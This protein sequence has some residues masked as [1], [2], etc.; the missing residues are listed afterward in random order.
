[1]YVCVCVC[2]CVCACVCV[3]V[4]FFNISCS[5]Q[6]SLQTLIQH[7]QDNWGTVLHFFKQ[8]YHQS[9]KGS[10]F[11][12]LFEVKCQC[13]ALDALPILFDVP[14]LFFLWLTFACDLCDDLYYTIVLGTT[15]QRQPSDLKMKMSQ[16][17]FFK[18]DL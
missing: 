14:N 11:L 3:C 6:G 5:N 16:P 7:L 9:Y 8:I 17:A 4:Q 13:Q 2:V 18:S 1:M 10:V 15:L 12:L